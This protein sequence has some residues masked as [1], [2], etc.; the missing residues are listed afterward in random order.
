LTLEAKS[1]EAASGLV[2][3]E[4][5]RQANTQLRSLAADRDAEIPDGSASLIVTPKQLADPDAVT[6]AEPHLRLCS[7]SDVLALANDAVEAIREIRAAATNLEGPS[8]HSLIRQR[9]ADRR[10][11]PTAV[12]ERIADRSVAG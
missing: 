4:N 10:L 11:L 9:M 8:A 6:I 2:S 12:R 5:V 1:E 3:M 7:L